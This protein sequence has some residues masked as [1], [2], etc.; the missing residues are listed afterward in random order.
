MQGMPT[1]RHEHD[2]I[3]EAGCLWIRLK[4]RTEN[5]ELQ[6]SHLSGLLKYY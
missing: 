2:V 1:F 6:H 5:C 4:Q 3:K